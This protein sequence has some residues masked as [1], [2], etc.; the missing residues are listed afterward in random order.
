[1]RKVEYHNFYCMNCGQKTFSLPRP[2]SHKY[3]KHHRKA[4]WC[5]YCK[6]MVNCIECKNDSE[7][8]DFKEKFYAGE[9]KEEAKVSIDYLKKQELIFT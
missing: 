5:P 3:S 1:M 9:Y 2:V 8:Y 4:L 7:V 6:I